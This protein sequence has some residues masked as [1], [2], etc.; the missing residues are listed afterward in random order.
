MFGFSLVGLDIKDAGVDA[1]KEP[2]G[3]PVVARSKFY[4]QLASVYDIPEEEQVARL[5]DGGFA[6]AL[7]ELVPDLPFPFEVPS[8]AL[9]PTCSSEEL[10]SEYLSL[11]EVG[12]GGPPCPLYGGVWLGNRMGVMEEVVRFYNYFGLKT[13]EERRIPPD[14]LSTELEFL[15]YLTY[16]EAAAPLPTLAVPYSRAQLDF[17]DRQPGRWFPMLVA[18]LGELEVSAFF[19]ALVDTTAR[20]LAA[21]RAHLGTGAGAPATA[22]AGS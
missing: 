12:T 22:S 14:H 17:L 5:A 9:T 16:R 18:R 21:D 19:A 8:E 4:G 11:F 15:L 13:S 10:H 6:A 1:L 2:E 7:V 3:G 20:F